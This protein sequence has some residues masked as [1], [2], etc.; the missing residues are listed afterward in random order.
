[1]AGDP[2][3]TAKQ[4][5]FVGTLLVDV[6]LGAFTLPIGADTSTNLL[7]STG[8]AVNSEPWA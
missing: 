2:E 8:T 6:Q 7:R 3:P 4:G 1:M 5:R